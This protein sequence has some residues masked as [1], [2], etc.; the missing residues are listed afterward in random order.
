MG[1]R[2]V[3]VE[4]GG[5][6]ESTAIKEDSCAVGTRPKVLGLEVGTNSTGGAGGFEGA[7]MG[8]QRR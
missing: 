4:G 5:D 8:A 3:N 2:E 1:E 7:G 6:R